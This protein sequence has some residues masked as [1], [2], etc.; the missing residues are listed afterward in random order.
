MTDLEASAHAIH[1]QRRTSFRIGPP[2][3]DIPVEIRHNSGARWEILFSRF[4]PPS[5]IV[6]V[7]EG[8][9]KA[10]QTPGASVETLA[11]ALAWVQAAS[12][13]AEM[14]NGGGA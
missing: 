10:S 9:A 1:A 4:M 14:E 6:A 3:F 13:A 2:P 11:F 7:V 8:I 5:S 12:D